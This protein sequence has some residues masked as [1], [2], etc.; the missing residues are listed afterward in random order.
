M[1]E[2]CSICLAPL[3]EHTSTLPCGHTFHST[4]MINTFRRFD[5]CPLCRVRPDITERETEVP[6]ERFITLMT[7]HAMEQERERR[8]YLSRCSH[9][10]RT[11]PSIKKL[12]EKM[13]DKQKKERDF[14]KEM[15]DY[16]ESQLQKIRRMSPLI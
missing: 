10:S 5:S 9:V 15:N 2:N 16:W 12:K 1:N 13:T 14:K 8:S 6:L 3:K 7:E 4:C 11:V